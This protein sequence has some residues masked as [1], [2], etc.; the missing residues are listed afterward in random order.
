MKRCDA[1]EITMADVEAVAVVE[2]V[3]DLLEVPQG[4][5]GWKATAR[6]EVVE[7]LATFDILE[8]EE[9]RCVG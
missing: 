3:D 2:A 4:F 9:P 5:G 7:Q 6:D 8:H 1:L